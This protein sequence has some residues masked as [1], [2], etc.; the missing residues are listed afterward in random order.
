MPVSLPFTFVPD[1]VADPDQVN[2]NFRAV[3]DPVG[4]S[5]TGPVGI[6]ATV[7]ANAAPGLFTNFIMLGFQSVAGGAALA[8]F[9]ANC[10]LDNTDTWR[11][12]TAGPAMSFV[13]RP[14]LLDWEFRWVAAGAAGAAIGNPGTGPGSWNSTILMGP[15]LTLC[16][17]TD[18]GGNL[19]CRFGLNAYL[20]PADMW[21]YQQAG[22][23]WS[24]VGRPSNSAL[25][26]RTAPVGVVG[27]NINF[28]GLAGGWINAMGLAAPTAN[29]HTAM[30]LQYID[31]AGN[32]QYQP[33][34]VGTALTAAADGMPVGAR[35]LYVV[36]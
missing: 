18:A 36:P 32:Q 13:A 1:T 33:V 21:H 34:L 10:Y 30:T 14:N 19:L 6:G 12:L 28:P 3:A 8:R 35:P 23:A 24:I 2:A 9:G 29:G 26:F 20:D 16:L 17:E 7:P 15:A 22:P 4:Q 11:Y 27:G 31:T 5:L 25:E